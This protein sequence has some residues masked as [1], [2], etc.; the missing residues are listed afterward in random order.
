MRKKLQKSI[1]SDLK[2]WKPRRTN[3]FVIFDNS[4]TGILKPSRSH[5]AEH[6]GASWLWEEGSDIESSKELV[7]APFEDG[8]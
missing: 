6:N 2:N 1:L 7:W 4:F 3:I 5:Q 8:G